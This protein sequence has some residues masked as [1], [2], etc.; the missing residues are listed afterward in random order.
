MDDPF[1]QSCLPDPADPKT[2]ERCKLDFSERERHREAYDLHRDL[3]KLRREDPAFRAQRPRGLDGAVL[4]PHALLLR[5]FV[6]GG[7]DRLLLVNLGRDLDL[8]PG[9]EPLLA[10]PEDC[11]WEVA[12]FSESPRYGGSG[13]APVERERNFH[14]Q[15]EAAVVLVPQRKG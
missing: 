1:I 13:M 11:S 8:K 2:F 15:G 10:P 6:E 7:G 3:L 4:G 9:P 5:Y 12:W 14:L